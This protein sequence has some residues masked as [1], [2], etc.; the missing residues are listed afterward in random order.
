MK[1]QTLITDIK[2]DT[3]W[4]NLL[5]QSLGIN[6]LFSK[7]EKGLTEV[8]FCDIVHK[9]GG[10]LTGQPILAKALM[11]QYA[12]QSR[13]TIYET[14]LNNGVSTEKTYIFK[15]WTWDTAPHVDWFKFLDKKSHEFLMEKW[16]KL[17]DMVMSRC[18]TTNIRDIFYYSKKIENYGLFLTRLYDAN[19]K[20]LAILKDEQE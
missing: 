12:T 3:L 20:V 10:Y 7:I 1:E 4:V 18:L 16:T 6:T 15:D 14:T 17:H 11:F 2:Q 5:A 13:P 8:E 19:N 9:K